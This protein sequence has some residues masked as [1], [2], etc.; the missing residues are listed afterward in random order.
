MGGGSVL[1]WAVIWCGCVQ[2]GIGSIFSLQSTVEVLA[3]IVLAVISRGRGVGSVLCHLL[4]SLV[5]LSLTPF[6]SLLCHSCGSS[7]VSLHG[8]WLLE[9]RD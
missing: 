7:G 9:Q 1:A 4:W 5:S 8:Y 2:L 6:S 3:F